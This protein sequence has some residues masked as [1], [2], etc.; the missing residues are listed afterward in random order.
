MNTNPNDIAMDLRQTASLVRD[1]RER[2]GLTQEQ[3]ADRLNISQPLVSQWETGVR[4]PTLWQLAAVCRLAGGR[5]ALRME[6][7]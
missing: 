4:Q 6:A 2:A 1:C 3:V 7:T 5:L